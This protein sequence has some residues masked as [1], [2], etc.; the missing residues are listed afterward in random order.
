V[1][2]LLRHEHHELV[3]LY[4]SRTIRVHL[5][6]YL[7]DLC[8]GVVEAK[9]GQQGLEL[10]LVDAAGVIVVEDLKGLPKDFYLF[11]S[12]LL[13]SLLV[14]LGYGDRTVVDVG[15]GGHLGLRLHADDLGGQ[16]RDLLLAHLELHSQCAIINCS[17]AS[18][19]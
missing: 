12:E 5:R 10:L 4:H 11:G 1:Y 2:Y 13:L 16:T 19:D 8:G 15:V 17:K 6:E 7:L 9:G 3:H 18:P 14:F